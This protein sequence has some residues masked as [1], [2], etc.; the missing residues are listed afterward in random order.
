M[1]VITSPAPLTEEH[2]LADFDCGHATLNE[3]LHKR[4]FKNQKNGAS[5][6]FVVNNDERV[7]GYYAIVTGSVERLYA[8]VCD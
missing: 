1:G 4:T 3:C 6:T 5:R 7:I 2:N 8:A